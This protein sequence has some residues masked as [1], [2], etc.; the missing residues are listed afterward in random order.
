MCGLVCGAFHEDSN[1]Y[2]RSTRK[3]MYAQT[4]ESNW[5][6]NC[7]CAFRHFGHRQFEAEEEEEAEAAAET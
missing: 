5:R 7:D 1:R 6:E 2:D 3:S 4:N